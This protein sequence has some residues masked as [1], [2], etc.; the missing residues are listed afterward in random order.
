M[1]VD[2]YVKATD[3]QPPFHHG[4]TRESYETFSMGDRASFDRAM[5]RLR[6]LGATRI[7]AWKRAD[8]MPAEITCVGHAE[9][10]TIVGRAGGAAWRCVVCGQTGVREGYG[11]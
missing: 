3:R 6:A 4:A 7:V 5:A 1:K 10:D 8:W 9:H 11:A 2:N